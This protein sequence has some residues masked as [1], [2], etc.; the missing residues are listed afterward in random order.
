MFY[1]H[2]IFHHDTDEGYPFDS[3]QP[4][5]DENNETGQ[6]DDRQ[7]DN[8]QQPNNNTALQ[9]QLLYPLSPDAT[10]STSMIA[11]LPAIRQVQ[12]GHLKPKNKK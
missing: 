5:E 6:G 12:P 11:V 8:D 1:N 9:L 7:E 10:W 4:N 2:A 3:E